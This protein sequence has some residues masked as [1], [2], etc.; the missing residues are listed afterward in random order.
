MEF[1]VHFLWQVLPLRAT[2]PCL[3][4]CLGFV[5]E[6]ACAL[7]IGGLPVGDLP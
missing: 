6:P 3:A 5:E 1:S 7:W 2:D 4:K